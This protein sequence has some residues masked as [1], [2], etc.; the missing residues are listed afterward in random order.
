MLDGAPEIRRDV[1]LRIDVSSVVVRLALQFVASERGWAYRDT[2]LP[3]CACVRV[4]DRRPSDDV[5]RL[6]VLVCED[7]PAACQL[8]LDTVLDGAARGIVLWDQPETL[9]STIDAIQVGSVVIPERVIDLAL[10]AP[11]LTERQHRTVHLVAAGRSNREIAATLHQSTSTTKR[12]L[13]ELMG[14]LDVANRAS[15]LAVANRLGFL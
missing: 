2:H 13:A 12:D 9:A 3:A 7:T 11:R 15:L 14:I 6:D 10:E 8:A 5:P 4:S 1:T